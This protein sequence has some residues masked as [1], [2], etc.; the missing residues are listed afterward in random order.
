MAGTA[1]SLAVAL[2]VFVS[3]HGYLTLLLAMFLEGFGLP[4]PSE[5]LFIPAGFL[6]HSHDLTFGGVLLAS[7]LGGLGGN[8]TGYTA[9]RLGGQELIS[10]YGGIVKLGD[11]HLSQ[12]RAWI[13]RHGG[14]T[15]FISR[16][17]GPIRAASIVGA[18]V[19]RMPVG[20]YVLYQAA[21]DLLWNFAWAF[22]A[23]LFGRRVTRLVDRFGITSVL[24]GLL[25][26]ALALGIW[27]IQAG[28]RRRGT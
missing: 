7:T 12:F 28:A 3:K 18:G 20:E 4:L 11:D 8:V 23:L 5:L 14:K 15:I 1:P 27:R 26:I 17:F 10:R 21:A 6:I 25:A 2:T 13:S 19:G 22:A 24:L 9:A 16:F